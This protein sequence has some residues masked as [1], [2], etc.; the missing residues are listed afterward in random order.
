MIQKKN[1]LI[2]VINKKTEK[3]FLYGIH[4]IYEND[5]NWVPPLDQDIKNHFSIEK[6]LL[7]AEGKAK[8]WVVIDEKAKVLGRIAAF[9]HKEKSKVNEQPTGGIGFY[10]CINSLD[11]SSL[12]FNTAI[13]WLKELGVEAV[14]G[15]ISLGENTSNW[16]LLVEGYVQQMYGM[17]YHP[18]Y[19]KN[20]FENF[21]FKVFYKQ[22]T[23]RIEPKNVSERIFRVGKWVDEKQRFTAR[24]FVE[25]EKGDFSKDLSEAYNKIWSSFKDDF[26]PSSGSDIQKMLDDAKF[27]LDPKL[28][29]IIYDG[30]RPIAIAI[31]IPDVNQLIKMID[32][33]LNLIN[34]VKLL[35]Y[36]K[37]KAITRVR[38]I[39]IGV[40]P[41]YQKQ[42]IEALIF[43]KTNQ[44]FDKSQYKELEFSWIG[45]YNT[46]MQ[47]TIKSVG[48]V[49]V[50]THVTYR[51]LLDR[52]KKFVRYPI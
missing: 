18:N 42:G 52:E 11:I 4:H 25:S 33:K 28:V 35:Y 43:Y 3:L 7:L 8:R 10:E 26:T 32:G 22:F 23:Y 51:Y 5:D 50:S 47:D 16:G 41:D 24:H 9:F 17:Q 14:E 31:M 2:E 27:V 12:L 34:M 19:Y 40:D 38:S 48:A 6:N 29:W 1:K 13:D 21:G 15:P 20:Q 49:K 37:T 39:V 30:I 44:F 46:K 36:K 45:D